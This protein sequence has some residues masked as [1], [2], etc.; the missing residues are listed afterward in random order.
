[1]FFENPI[2]KY[3]DQQKSKPVQILCIDEKPIIDTKDCATQTEK[4][5]T[6][7]SFLENVMTQYRD[8][9][10]FTFV[11]PA[12]L[13]FEMYLEIRDWV[14]RNFLFSEDVH[15]KRVENVQEQVRKWNQS[16][17]RGKRLMC[18]VRPTWQTMSTRTA[19]YKNNCYGIDCN[20][21]RDILFLDKERNIVKTE[22]MVNMRYMSRYLLPKGYQLTVQPGLEDL[23]VG[24]LCMGVGIESSSHQFGCI[25]ETV[26]SYDIVTADGDLLH[27]TR[28]DNPDLFYTL[29]WSHGS[30][31]ILVA[32][33][34]RVIPVKSYVHVHYLPCYHQ[35]HLDRT[36]K[37]LIH[38]ENP[39]DFVEATVY[40]KNESVIMFSSF[41]DANLMADWKNINF[42]NCFW[43]PCYYE[44]VK[45]ALSNGGF[46][47]YIPIGHYQRRFSRSI[48]WE[49][50]HIIPFA[51]HPLYRYC[52]GWLGVPKVS[53]LKKS[54][55]PQIRKELFS[56]HVVE[57][58][59]VPLD[60]MLESV[61][62]FHDWFETYPL[63][64]YP[65]AIYDHSP[66]EG[67]IRNPL[68]EPTDKS[69]QFYVYL[70]AFGV[71]K[72]IQEQKFWN[73]EKVIH[74]M[75]QYTRTVNGYKC[76]CSDTFMTKQDFRQMFHHE[77]YDRLREE[78]NC[79]GAFPEIYD[80]VKREGNVIM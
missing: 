64:L 26:E 61:N 29:P 71:P 63:Q 15:D 6:N 47:E 2:L 9:V 59:I 76:L 77:T 80:K 79:I 35:E 36:I 75:E 8:W 27:I 10:I 58:I 49:L 11:L 18:T 56:K 32:V 16:D 67:M 24:G 52:F 20:N 31:G 42:V 23:T 65:V 3:L 33:E 53:L 60:Q 25:Q 30:L 73:S 68:T 43:K 74:E 66:S 17:L 21:L 48:F 37:H 70:G 4:Q 41:K 55:T 5:I 40:S 39:P 50:E 22:P 57:G 54:M 51:N 28:K 44:H 34:L 1:M 46:S 12:S 62:H 38:S 69:C 72:K 19:T 45:N 7:A 13:C 14:C 78:Y